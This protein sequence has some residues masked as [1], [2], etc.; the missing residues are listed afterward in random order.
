MQASIK[1]FFYFIGSII[2]TFLFIRANPVY[3]TFSFQLMVFG[4]AATVWGIQVIGA[5]LFLKEKKYDFLCEAGKVCFW[6]SAFL[7]LPVAINFYIRPST[8]VQL[9]L[10]AFGVLASVLMMAI[11]FFLFLKRLHLSYGWLV[12]WLASLCIAVPLQAK[13]VG[14]W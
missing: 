5:L 13:L 10:S 1:A 11:L 14:F 9:Q 2:T 3:N 12:I 4:I 8:N 6:G 7:L